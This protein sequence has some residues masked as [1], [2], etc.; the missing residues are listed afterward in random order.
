MSE[1]AIQPLAQLHLLLLLQPRPQST[2]ESLS[3]L[4]PLLPNTND[5]VLSVTEHPG[6]V[7]QNVS[8]PYSPVRTRRPVQ[9]SSHADTQTLTTHH[10]SACCSLSIRGLLVACCLQSVYSHRRPPRVCVSVLLSRSVVVHPVSRP[11][12]PSLSPGPP[13][14]T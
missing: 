7:P 13:L 1:P 12:T 5:V 3:S 6:K 10:L 8:S 2:K 9:L 14:P 4:P 11:F